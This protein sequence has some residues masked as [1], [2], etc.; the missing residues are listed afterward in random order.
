MRGREIEYV[1][2]SV[3]IEEECSL[4]TRLKNKNKKKNKN[5]CHQHWG[6]M[7]KMPAS[8]FTAAVHLQMPPGLSVT[9]AVLERSEYSTSE[10]SHV[11]SDKYSNYFCC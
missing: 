8:S 1:G 2:V 10:Y 3:Y 7:P 6:E 9:A 5:H 11:L 4:Q